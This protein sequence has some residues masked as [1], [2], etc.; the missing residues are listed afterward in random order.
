[1]TTQ[2]I[3]ALGLTLS[4]FS[5]TQLMALDFNA[6]LSTGLS[7]IDNTIQV[8]LT[9][10]LNNTYLHKYASIYYAPIIR[11]Q[12]GAN[13]DFN[14]MNVG[15]NI[16][17][18]YNFLSAKNTLDNNLLYNGAAR[19]QYTEHYKINNVV[20]IDLTPGYWMGKNIIVFADLGFNMAQVSQNSTVTAGAITYNNNW[21]TWDP[22]F[23]LGLGFSS[24][25]TQHLSINA[26]YFFNYYKSI[27]KTRDTITQVEGNSFEGTGTETT[28]YKPKSNTI[29]FGITY[30][31]E[32][33]SKHKLN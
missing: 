13:Q 9:S 26:E 14:R 29:L 12:L 11:A 19:V 32:P 10:S 23:E 8:N 27:K 1:M 20:G 25:F 33:Y 31:F 16:H 17:W 22:G 24:Y 3:K 5:A 18:Q 30:H 28:T 2:H 7:S 6:G 4:L 21:T 15:T